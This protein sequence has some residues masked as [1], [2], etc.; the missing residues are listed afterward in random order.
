MDL[1]ILLKYRYF[2]RP[3][4]MDQRRFY[5]KCKGINLLK[6]RGGW[7]KLEIKMYLLTIKPIHPV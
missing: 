7:G 4:G 5:G 1:L 2:S 6:L 3:L